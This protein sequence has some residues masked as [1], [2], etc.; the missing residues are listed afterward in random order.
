[1]IKLNGE[2]YR[3]R[4]RKWRIEDYKNF[5]DFA[6]SNEVRNIIKELPKKDRVNYILKE[7][8]RNNNI[9]CTANI[10]KILQNSMPLNHPVP[11]GTT[12]LGEPF[13]YSDPETWEY[14]HILFKPDVRDALY[15]LYHNRVYKAFYH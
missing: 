5:L 13:I 1:M 11:R 4:G 2:P 10:K 8:E 9:H 12:F 3:S 7:F 14:A 15:E 6:D